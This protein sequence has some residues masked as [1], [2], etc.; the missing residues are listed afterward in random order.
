VKET[1]MKKP[2]IIL[3]SLVSV[4]LMGCAEKKSSSGGTTNT[5]DSDLT[6][7]D[8][9][10]EPFIPT[11]SGPG[12]GPGS[13]WEY[14]ATASF[15]LVSVDRLME[16][17]MQARNNP[18]NVRINMNL[19]NKGGNS[20][21]GTVSISYDDGGEYYEGFFTSGESAGDNKYN[22]WFEK[23]GKDVYHGFFEDY[24]G[25]IVV[26]VDDLVSAGDGQAPDQAS[27]RVYFKNFDLAY[28]PNPLTGYLPG[29]GNPRTYCWFISIGP[30]DCRSWKKGNGVDTTKAVNPDNG[31][32]LLGSFSGLDIED[33][34]NEEF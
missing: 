2:I 34:F 16:Y 18:K 29:F 21:G 27:G 14:G 32:K 4:L 3:L 12:Q 6:V 24:Y 28:A 19:T 22:I 33:A 20:Y 30:Y 26:V 8:P 25:A 15:K 17:T 5:Q 10:E 13:D 11:G 31:Y 1:V 9:N 23:D 7:I